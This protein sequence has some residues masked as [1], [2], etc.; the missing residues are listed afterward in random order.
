MIEVTSKDKVEQLKETVSNEEATV[1]IEKDDKVL[2]VVGVQETKEKEEI[3]EGI[4]VDE[5]AEDKITPPKNIPLSELEYAAL[6]KTLSTITEL[7][8]TAETDEAKAQINLLEMSIWDD[9]VKR[10]GFDSVE[11]AQSSGY[12]FGLKRHFV[13]ECIKK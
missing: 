2:E 7:K 13:I 10:F 5:A 4:I 12:T 6:T 1:T 8:K 9:M 3:S 11:S